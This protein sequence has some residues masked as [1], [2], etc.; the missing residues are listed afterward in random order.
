MN[1]LGTYH[2]LNVPNS[3]RIRYASTRGS[4]LGVLLSLTFHIMD[5]PSKVVGSFWFTEHSGR[6][7]GIVKVQTSD[8]LRFYIGH[9]KWKEEKEDTAYIHKYGSPL[10]VDQL[11]TFLGNMKGTY[12]YPSKAPELPKKNQ[13]HN[14]LL[15]MFMIGIGLGLA[16][17]TYFL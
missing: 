15:G 11:A 4:K 9:A 2:N 7:F 12:I 3:M 16:V 17:A 14:E 8:S 5:N 6:S 10:N 1:N 13:H